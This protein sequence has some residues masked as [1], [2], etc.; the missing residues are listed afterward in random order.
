MHEQN[1]ESSQSR[2][3]PIAAHTEGVVPLPARVLGS[4]VVTMTFAKTTVLHDA[5]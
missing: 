3:L 5:I 1:Q 2:H 4:V